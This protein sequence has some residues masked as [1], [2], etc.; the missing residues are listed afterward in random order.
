MVQQAQQDRKVMLDLMVQPAPLV[1][2]EI[3]EKQ[4]Q[5]E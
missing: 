2:R 5:Q 1:L 3:L 4:V